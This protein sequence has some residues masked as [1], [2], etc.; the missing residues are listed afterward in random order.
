M[1]ARRHAAERGFSL[2]EVLVVLLIVGLVSTILIQGMA[3]VFAARERLAPYIDR[4]EDAARLSL[5]F[6]QVAGGAVPDFKGGAHVFRGDGQG[7]SGLT[8]APLGGRVGAPT[9]FSLTIETGE[10][11][12]RALVERSENGPTIRLMTWRAGEPGADLAGF[13]YW[14]GTT[15]VDKWPVGSLGQRLTAATGTLVANIDPPQLPRLVRFNGVLAGQ[16]WV[17]VAHPKGPDAPLPRLSDL[18]R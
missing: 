9:V 5:W 1:S 14:D 16:P 11:G 15:W 4:G 7:L 18:F 6:R 17:L 2:V 3:Q 12:T 13:R 10:D 8:L